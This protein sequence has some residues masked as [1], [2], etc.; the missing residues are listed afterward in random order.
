MACLDGRAVPRFQAH[1]PVVV[2]Y[3]GGGAKVDF[4][5][6]VVLPP[7]LAMARALRQPHNASATGRDRAPAVAVAVAVA[8]ATAVAAAAAGAR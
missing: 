3:P 1:Q 5:L 6:A 4:V 2:A 7:A 8:A